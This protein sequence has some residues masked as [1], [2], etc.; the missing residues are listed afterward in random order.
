MVTSDDA[1]GHSRGSQPADDVITQYRQPPN[2]C[3]QLHR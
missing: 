1:D 2:D 3:S